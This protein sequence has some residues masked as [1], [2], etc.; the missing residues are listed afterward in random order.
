M[1]EK[2]KF[3]VCRLIV[4]LLFVAFTA[5]AFV[6]SGHIYGEYSVFNKWV[7]DNS[8]LQMLYG[9]IPALIRS[10]Q[11]I[12]IA[13]LLH[14][15]IRLVMTRIIVKSK[16]GVTI[17]TLLSSFIKWIIFIAAILLVLAAWGVNTTALIASAGI[18][19]LVIGLGAQS[20][21]ADILAGLF[22]V[23]EGEYQVG[24][25]VVVEGW[26]GTVIEIGIRTTKIED[27]GGNIKII[28]NSEIKS[29]VNQTQALSVAK[30]VMSIEYGE[31]LPRVELVIR[32]NLAAIKEAIPD[33][34]EGPYYKGVTAL[35]SSSVDL[36]FLAKC[37][38]ENFYQVQR[39]LTRELKL[40]F[41]KNGINIPFP[42]IVVNQPP[43]FERAASSAEHG[44]ANAFLDEQKELSKDVEEEKE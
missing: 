30:T 23:V 39:D 41:D 16:R 15:F 19:S 20:L 18:L 5:L 43:T 2:K 3:S 32:D 25:I 37:K 13:V 1:K 11:I 7:S 27:A 8:V 26:R 4:L 42:Q 9:K 10:I 17:A 21:V 31:S 44:D 22:I 40:L 28:N 38:E 14:I 33:I 6:Y 24:D 36:L 34:V 12:T 35:S 29:I